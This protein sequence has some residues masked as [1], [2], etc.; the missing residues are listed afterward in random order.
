[1]KAIC[2]LQA[3]AV[4]S[5]YD[6]SDFLLSSKCDS[7]A[8][9]H[10]GHQII[11][12]DGSSVQMLTPHCRDYRGAQADSRTG[13]VLPLSSHALPRRARSPNHQRPSGRCGPSIV[14]RDMS[15]STGDIEYVMEAKPRSHVR[16]VPH[17][18][19]LPSHK[20]HKSF[21]SCR[22]GRTGPRNARLVPPSP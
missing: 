17:C 6:A 16:R 8:A 11:S 9:E 2:A 4:D 22:H 7:S 3:R 13:P 5:T 10:Y 14:S 18:Y 1:M 20:L 15:N 19:F 21:P 12:L